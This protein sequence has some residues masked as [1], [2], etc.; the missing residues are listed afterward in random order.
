MK[1]NNKSILLSVLLLLFISFSVNTAYGKE[2]EGDKGKSLN[3]V[4]TKAGDSYRLWINNVNFPLNRSGVLADVSIATSGLVSKLQKGAVYQDHIFLFSGGFYLSGVDNNGKKWTNAVASASR[5]QD[6]TTGPYGKSNDPKAQ[7]YVVTTND[8]PFGQSWIDW[9]DAVAMGAN[10]YDGDGDGVYNP[11]DKNGDGK[12]QAN[13]DRPDLIG[14]ATAWCV[15][16]DDV[17]SAQR[18]FNDVSPQG[19]EIRQTVFAFRSKS[20]TGNIIFVRYEIENKGNQQ[21]LDSTYFTVWADPDLGTATDDKVGCD[22]LLNAGYVYNAGPTDVEY[23]SAPPCFLIDFFQGPASYTGVATDTAYEVNGKFR[24]VNKLSGYKNLGLS[25]FTHYLNGDLEIGDPANQDD[26]RNYQHGLNKAGKE[27][28]PCTWSH[29]TVTGVDCKLV[30]NKFWY[31]GDPVTGQGWVCKDGKDQRIMLN[32]GPF[33]LVKGQPV[34]IVVAYVVGRG[35]SNLNSITVAKDID[36]KAQLIFDNNFPS[37]PPP[38]QMDYSVKSNPNFLDIDMVT[39]TTL[40]YR[41]ID[42]VQLVDRDVQGFYITQYRTSQIAPTVEGQENAKIV[43]SYSKN[44]NVRS[45]SARNLTGGFANIY[46]NST[47]TLLLDSA[48]YANSNTGRLKLRLTQD[49]FSSSPFVKGKTYYFTLTSFTVNHVGLYSRGD[50]TYIDSTGAAYEEFESQ[51]IPVV[52][53]DDEFN[54]ALDIAKIDNGGNLKYLVPNPSVLTG[55]NYQ[56]SFFRDSTQFTST[57]KPYWKLTN[58][59]TNKVLLDSMK[60]YNTDTTDYSGVIA[61][62]ILLRIANAAPN[63]GLTAPVYSDSSN[64]WFRPYNDSTANGVYYV[65]Q[66]I[67]QG[68][69]INLTGTNSGLAGVRSNSISADRIRKVE[70]RF[71]SSNAGKAYRYINGYKGSAITKVNNWTYAGNI[72]AS[73]TVGKG[74]IGM[75]GQGFVDV[76][77]TAWVKDSRNGEEKQLAVGFTEKSPVLGTKKGTPDGIYNPGDSVQASSEVIIIFDAPYDPTGSQVEYTG[78]GLTLTNPATGFDIAKGNNIKDSETKVTPTQR[79]I[80][81]SPWFNAL[82]VVG[83]SQKNSTN[84][85]KEGEIL[86]IPVSAYPYTELD[87]Y[88]FSTARYEN[89]AQAKKD[90]FNKINVF[91]NPLFAYN[92]ATSYTNGNTDEPFVTFSNLPTEVTIKIYSLSGTLVR[93]LHT[94]NKSVPTSPFLRWN[95]QNE[96]GLRVASGMYL[97]TV[98]CP[99]FGQKV[100]KFAI[101]MPQKQIQKY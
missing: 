1:I 54:P 31:S 65:G 59:T 55:D 14:D 61:D 19:I 78:A 94:S 10:F 98:D 3:K 89:S 48:L 91:P 97:A 84:K 35:S 34:S 22:T 4:T 56:V 20:V 92:P 26:A 77:F 49:A 28:D 87:K 44:N 73:D 43:A 81:N 63:I 46:D 83:L 37:P 16:N 18:T 52:F 41:A 99:G 13:E 90:L 51:I 79:R 40:K 76:P 8:A 68:K 15:Y 53:N 58:L 74:P 85:W 67:S 50:S 12:W 36:K 33:K 66:D 95:L 70:L 7:L 2:K 80:A 60:E 27:I 88:T 69:T 93:T 6:Y 30:N 17:P 42:T 75:L 25:S 5:I 24:G 101:I 100:L 38:P 47:S 57:Y 82:Y 62:G 86:T 11:V 96:N 39:D 9:K 29:G 23:G 72:I 64:L 32:T 71:G 45:I 21:E